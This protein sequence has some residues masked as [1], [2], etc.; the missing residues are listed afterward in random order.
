VITPVSLG[1]IHTPQGTSRIAHV[2]PMSNAAASKQWRYV[3]WDTIGEIGVSIDRIGQAAGHTP[4]RLPNQLPGGSFHDIQR[5][6]NVVV[7]GTRILA[8]ARIERGRP[9]TVIATGENDHIKG[10][11]SI[12]YPGDERRREGQPEFI[13]IATLGAGDLPE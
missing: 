7:L 5:V 2:K 11:A 1:E 3:G 12:P 13:E 9:A 8:D 4:H 10:V 6:T